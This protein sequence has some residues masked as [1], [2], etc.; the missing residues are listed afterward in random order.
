MYVQIYFKELEEI[1][2]KPS[3]H[4]HIA[5]LVLCGVYTSVFILVMDILAIFFNF[6]EKMEYGGCGNCRVG[7][8]VF[9]LTN[10]VIELFVLIGMMALICLLRREPQHLSKC[11]ILNHSNIRT[12]SNEKQTEAAH[13][14]SLVI[15]ML[16]PLWYVSSHIGYVIVSWLTEPSK[17]TSVALLVMAVYLYIY[18]TTRTMYQRLKDSSAETFDFKALIKALFGGLWTMLGVCIVIAAFSILPLPTSPLPSYIEN[19]AQIF[20]VFL[21]ALVSYKLISVQDSDT[22]KFL[23]NFEKRCGGEDI[24]VSFRGIKNNPLTTYTVNSIQ[25]EINGENQV[26]TLPE[27]EV[28]LKVKKQRDKVTKAKL[29][30]E[31][32]QNAALQENYIRWLNQNPNPP[33][34]SPWV[35]LKSFRI[36]P[37]CM[38]VSFSDNRDAVL[39]PPYRTD[40]VI[41]REENNNN[42]IRASIRLRDHADITFIADRTILS[43]T[44]VHIRNIAMPNLISVGINNNA[45]V[46]ISSFNITIDDNG[47]V[48]LHLTDYDPVVSGIEETTV[49]IGYFR[50]LYT[51]DNQGL[52][53]AYLTTDYQDNY[54]N[55]GNVVGSIASKM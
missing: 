3:S 10:L 42:N 27:L 17:S 39:L 9:I 16:V 21:A 5:A 51:G 48:L 40:F 13:L 43:G 22:Q 8:D 15:F 38:I 31:V 47:D 2:L 6:F 12:F 7:N 14:W 24:R 32:L 55:V 30:H 46:S 49:I 45:P 54:A 33:I 19:I 29:Q 44:R 28:T 37:N 53:K 34:S 1:L 20:L 25:V 35:S 11:F 23:K 52:L 4:H 50:K 36:L 18:M 26:F 41:R